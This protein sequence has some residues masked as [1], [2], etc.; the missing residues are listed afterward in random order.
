[1]PQLD[2]LKRC[3]GPGGSQLRLDLLPIGSGQR[4]QLVVRSLLHDR[5]F[6]HH[7]DEVGVDDRA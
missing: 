6:F 5:A 2:D 3:T 1:V 4:H 7:Q